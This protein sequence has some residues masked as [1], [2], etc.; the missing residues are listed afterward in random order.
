MQK[1]EIEKLI[2]T[3]MDNYSKKFKAGYLPTLDK[4]E[5]EIFNAI[6]KLEPKASKTI[7]NMIFE[8]LK[9]LHQFYVIKEMVEYDFQINI[10]PNK[11]KGR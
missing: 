1:E 10:T 8:L 2:N 11:K 7:K 9:C 4:L 6:S 5:I 3:M